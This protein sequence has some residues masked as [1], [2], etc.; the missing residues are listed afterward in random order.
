MSQE[1]KSL[2][3]PSKNMIKLG[4]NEVFYG[5]VSIYYERVL[6]KKLAVEVG[7]GLLFRNYLKN[8]FQD[9]PQSQSDK[10]LLGP[11]FNV[12]CKYY[13]YIPGESFYFSSD[14][15]FRRYRTQYSTTS[16][17]GNELITFNEFEQRSI[18][19]FGVGFIQCVDQHFTVDYFLSIGLAGVLNQNM[20]PSYNQNT[21]EYNYLK[22]QFRDV[23][24]HFTAGLKFGYRF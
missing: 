23:N 11:S 6:T 4:I 16:I 15:K 7:S 2:F 13:P 8:F 18:F 5:D 17:S 10:M 14:F 9:V 3:S 21:N 22:D 19:R 24:L 20:V 12:K 1:S